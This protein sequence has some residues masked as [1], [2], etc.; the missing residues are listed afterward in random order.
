[1]ESQRTDFVL[2][3]RENTEITNSEVGGLAFSSDSCQVS[4]DA[5]SSLHWMHLFLNR[6]EQ[7]PE[8]VTSFLKRNGMV[9][10]FWEALRQPK[11]TERLAGTSEK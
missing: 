10:R 3:S 4:A 8:W 6:V 1:M 11:S 9:P 7:E 5:V 2:Q